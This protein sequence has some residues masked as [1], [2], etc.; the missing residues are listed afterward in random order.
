MNDVSLNNIRIGGPKG[1]DLPIIA[2]SM[3]VNINEFIDNGATVNVRKINS[4]MVQLK[5][6]GFNGFIAYFYLDHNDSN[7]KILKELLGKILDRAKINNLFVIISSNIYLAPTEGLINHWNTIVS[8][9]S[10]DQEKIDCY[11]SKFKGRI[12]EFTNFLNEY[13][14]FGG[15]YLQDEPKLSEL[16]PRFPI[17][18]STNLS[19]YDN[20]NGKYY[21]LSNRYRIVQTLLSSEKV[22]IVNLIGMHDVQTFL[23]NKGYENYLNAFSDILGAVSYPYLWSYDIYPITESNYLLEQNY[24]YYN[25]ALIPDLSKNGEVSVRYNEFYKDLQL[26]HQNTSSKG[27]IFWTYVQ[28]MEFMAGKYYHP[29]ANEQYLRFAIFSSLAMGCQGIMYWTYHQ[30]PNQTNELYLSAALDREGNKT[31]V[32]FYAQKINSEI[33]KYNYIFRNC[34]LEEWYLTYNKGSVTTDTSDM[35]LL[36][37]LGQNGLGVLATRISNGNKEYIIIVNADITDYQDIKLYFNYNDEI[38]R[39]LTIDDEEYQPVESTTLSRTLKPGG[40]IIFGYD[41]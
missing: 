9:K 26:F 15:I 24:H 37:K 2:S 18:G 33:R 22:I 40:Y 14:S 34:K 8:T 17:N 19:D 35:G 1:S 32:W 36:V 27:S 11:I 41:I 39:E 3:V 6:C 29:I 21:C 23:E 31:P 30:R 7:E 10:S 5:S 28:S 4:A 38:I 25:E 20:I 16:T 12:T 13:E